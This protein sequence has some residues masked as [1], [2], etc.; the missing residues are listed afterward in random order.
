MSFPALV[1]QKL[2]GI[3]IFRIFLAKSSILAYI[4]QKIGYFE[5][6]HDYDVTVRSYLGCWYFFGMYGKRRPLALTK[7]LKKSN[8]ACLYPPI[9]LKLLT[10]VQM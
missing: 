6:G 7:G 8:A 1:S 3:S 4:S 9:V 2:C 5:L 10:I